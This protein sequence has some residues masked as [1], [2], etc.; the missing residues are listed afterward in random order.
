MWPRSA[1]ARPSASPANF[2]QDVAPLAAEVNQLI[3]ANREIVERARTQVGNLAHALKTPLSVLI[4]EAD[5][6]SP[7]LPE[8]V[9]E[10]T[11]IMRQQVTF[12]LDRARAAA[13]ARTSGRGHRGQAGGRGAGSHV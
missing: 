11:E 13:R 7:S 6:Q 2:P 1:A 9:R 5:S 8:K 4:N 10:Q 12:Y 3:D